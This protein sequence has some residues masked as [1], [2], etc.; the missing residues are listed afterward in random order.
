MTPQTD[1]RHPARRSRLWSQPI[2]RLARR[3]G[4]A[5]A[6]PVAVVAPVRAPLDEGEDLLRRLREA[7]L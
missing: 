1:D 3:K 4:G 7:G 6:E 5:A 2:V